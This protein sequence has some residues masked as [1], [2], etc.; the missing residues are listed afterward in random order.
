MDWI[1]NNSTLIWSAIVG[2][3]GLVIGILCQKYV[4]EKRFNSKEKKIHDKLD[5]DKRNLKHKQ[6]DVE[7]EIRNDLRRNRG[8]WDKEKKKS[9]ANIL[10]QINQ[11]QTQDKELF[12]KNKYFDSQINELEEKLKQT[13]Q[14][15]EK[16]QTEREEK[17]TFLQSKE[18]ENSNSFSSEEAKAE[19]EKRIETS[20]KKES[21]E[22][23]EN[24][25]NQL[26]SQLQNQY[27]TDLTQIIKS[28]AKTFA[29]ENT[30]FTL[31]LPDDKL[32]GQVIGREGRNI[33]SFEAITGTSIIVDETPSTILIS[34]F[35]P[36]KKEVA[37]QTVEQL[38][39]EGKINPQR[40]EDVF[41]EKK[42]KV[43]S[44]LR[45]KGLQAAK[46]LQIQSL[47][48]EILKRTGK[49]A[50]QTYLGKTNLLD[51]LQDIA[52]LAESIAKDLKEDAEIP[53]RAA[54]LHLLGRTLDQKHIGSAQQLTLDLV[55]KCGE[56]ERVIRC[57]SQQEDWTKAT[58]PAAL[59]LALSIETANARPGSLTETLKNYLL[60]QT[61]IEALLTEEPSVRKCYAFLTQ[62]H[63]RI[64]VQVD[65][66]ATDMDYVKI[67]ELCHKVKEKTTLKGAISVV[68]SSKNQHKHYRMVS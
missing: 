46:A 16:N 23:I 44:S 28:Q 65:N 42:S 30:V 24:K 67:R 43:N 50:Y 2:S 11:L 12:R 20:L 5:K 51:H 68:F 53:K 27:L 13:S 64:W 47:H 8:N 40:I 21:E 59:I 32:K 10:A 39:Q 17:N 1:N 38:L 62:H 31:S 61:E 3:I 56:S 34:G 25:V 35:D 4:L 63:T 29:T 15:I 48:P 26:D 7:N 22:L 57:L 36:I 66:N 55:K 45:E 52:K 33:R 6:K 49:L 14:S 18:G 9:K 58:D 54:Y 41:K 37:K 19:L 60:R